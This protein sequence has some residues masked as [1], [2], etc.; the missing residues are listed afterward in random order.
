MFGKNND[1][2]GRIM[3]D[4]SGPSVAVIRDKR[5]VFVEFEGALAEKFDDELTFTPR[6][7]IS[8][9]PARIAGYYDHTILVDGY[10]IRVMDT[11]AQIALKILEATK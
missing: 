5:T 8:L 3:F 10:K 4:N 2:V 9:N 6:G 7:K 11:Y 1:Q